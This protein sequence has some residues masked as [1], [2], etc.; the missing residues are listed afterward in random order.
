MAKKT[1]YLNSQRTTGSIKLREGYPLGN[2]P[3][4]VKIACHR[5]NPNITFD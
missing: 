3:E 1:I 2:V 5:E 4:M